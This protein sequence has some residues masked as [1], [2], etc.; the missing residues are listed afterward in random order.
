MKYSCVF[1][2]ADNT[3]F[4]YD[5]AEG[6]ALESTFQEY[7]LPMNRETVLLYRS[8]NKKAW[9]EFEKGELTQEELRSRRFERLFDQLGLL[10]DP[11]EVSTFYLARLAE[12]S[13]L[14]ENALEVLKKAASVC[15]CCIVTN[16]IADVQHKR[17]DASP[18]LPFLRGLV[19]SEE[20]GSQKP[21]GG[22]YRAALELCGNPPKEKVLMVGDSLTSDILGGIRFGIDTCWYNPAGKARAD[23]IHP[24]VEIRDLTEIPPLLGIQ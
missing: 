6:R 19:I 2:D 16:G 14:L 15:T 10:R 7:G 20:V 5:R 8:I 4:D 9:E 3:L 18:L 22:I 23:G 21:D 1:F 24:T 11:E 12:G 13:F 17:F